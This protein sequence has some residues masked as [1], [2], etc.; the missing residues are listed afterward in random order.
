MAECSGK[1]REISNKNNSKP[2]LFGLSQGKKHKIKCFR[3]EILIN[4]FCALDL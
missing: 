3:K 1:V 4:L 2:A